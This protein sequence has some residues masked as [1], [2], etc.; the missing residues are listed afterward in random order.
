[1]AAELNG[2]A[3]ARDCRQ[4]LASAVVGL[5]ADEGARRR[6]DVEDCI[7]EFG[8]MTEVG[9]HMIERAVTHRCNGGSHAS[10]R[11]FHAVVTRL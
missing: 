10:A 3:A 5:T 6:A 2:R 4:L 1:M 11:I 7:R 9:Q 8:A